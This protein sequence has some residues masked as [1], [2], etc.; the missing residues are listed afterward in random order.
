MNAIKDSPNAQVHF[1]TA[2][3]PERKRLGAT[4]YLQIATEELE[5]PGSTADP[6]SD[7]APGSARS[8]GGG[9]GGAE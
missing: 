7:G 4:A 8:G 2:K 3:L 9:G 6:K 5:G 1:S